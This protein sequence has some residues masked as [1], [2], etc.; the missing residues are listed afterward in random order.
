[1]TCM[2]LQARIIRLRQLLLKIKNK[3]KIELYRMKKSGFLPLFMLTRDVLI[4]YILYYI[5]I[6]D[7][8]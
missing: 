8:K 5:V 1:M 3:V 7:I 6:V 2:N 4:L